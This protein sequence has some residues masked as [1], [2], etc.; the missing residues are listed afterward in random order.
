VLKVP[1]K[2]QVYIMTTDLFIAETYQR[3]KRTIT[4]L[5]DKLLPDIYV[6]SF[7]KSNEDDDLKRP[8]L[9]VG[10]NTLSQWAACTPLPGQKPGWTVASNAREAK[11][12]YAFWLQNEELV[13]GG[14][15]YDPV[16]GWVKQL[17]YYYSDEEE[18]RD[19]DRTFV[20]GQ[21]IQNQFV[22]IFIAHAK[23]LHEEGIIKAKF[24]REIPIVIHELEYYDAP[25]NWTKQAN[26]KSLIREFLEWVDSF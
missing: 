18:K 13:I 24:G 16:T 21:Q 15:E 26:A 25:I 22:D 1:G 10:F 3:I 9:T 12:N 6:I 7:Y 2:Q 23:K 5:D 20:L 14:S 19:F 11:W 4:N 8:L 17:P